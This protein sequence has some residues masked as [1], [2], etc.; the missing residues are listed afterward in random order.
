MTTLDL[1]KAFDTVDHVILME[2]AL[3]ST[4]PNDL[5]PWS[6]NYGRPR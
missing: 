6:A 4:L 3:K 1:S 2:E 5:K